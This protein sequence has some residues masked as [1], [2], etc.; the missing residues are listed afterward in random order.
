MKR[1]EGDLAAGQRALLPGLYYT[2]PP[3][4]G[5][6]ANRKA[7]VLELAEPIASYS[8]FLEEYYAAKAA[9]EL[10]RRR[11]AELQKTVATLLQRVRRRTEAQEQ[12]LLTADER[13]VHRRRGDLIT[14]NLHLLSK[15]MESAQVP[16]YSREPGGDG[17]YPLQ[18]VSLD[19]MLTPPQNAAR[20]YKLY[21]KARNAVPILE[22]R[23]AA[24]RAEMEYLLSVQDAI[25]RADGARA[26]QDIRDEL[27]AGGYRKAAAG[28]KKTKHKPVPPLRYVS[29]GGFTVFVG[30]NG[31]QNDM[32]VKTA[33]P[34]DLWLHVQK[35]PGSHV[36]IDGASASGRPGTETVEMAASLA[37]WHSSAR[38]SAKVP[39][40][41]C[42]IRRVKKPNGAAPGMVIYAG[43]ETYMVEPRDYHS[44]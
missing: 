25:G 11:G 12:E 38:A 44:L 5:G 21:A 16:D 2:L 32:L 8:D 26:L 34:D 42:P 19:P 4:P 3:K 33:R 7:N 35:Q 30:R 39:V 13:E 24:G 17:A 40:D 28:A 1:A 43:Y 14:A 20:Q 41:C 10:T 36:V 15:G 27:A 31:R 9:G 23:I 6:W 29:P 18:A 22:A 37:A